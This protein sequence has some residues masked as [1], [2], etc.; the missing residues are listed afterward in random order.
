MKPASHLSISRN[1]SLRR[2]ARE[3][4]DMAREDQ[5]MRLS[6][7]WD[8]KVDRRNAARLKQVVAQIGWPT[9]SKVGARAS[10]MAWLL[11]Q[12]ADH[13]IDFQKQ[14]LRL[15]RRQ[16][17]GEVRKSEIA[18]LDDRVRVGEKKPQRYGTQFITSGG[19]GLEPRPIANL[20][21]LGKLRKQMG[22]EPF[23]IYAAKV[24]RLFRNLQR[25]RQLRSGRRKRK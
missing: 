1:A 14:C 12:H 19:G 7:G 3:L 6:G 11:A 15:L 21:N 9:C 20:G 17:R 8:K 24:Y 5:R 2:I 4:L 10:H 25:K 16:P 18:Y 23:K 22:M 13:D